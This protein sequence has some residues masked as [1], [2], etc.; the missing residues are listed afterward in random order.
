MANCFVGHINAHKPYLFTVSI[1]NLDGCKIQ[2]RYLERSINLS[3]TNQFRDCGFWQNVK[4]QM[5]ILVQ[6]EFEK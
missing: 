3:I 2:F 4:E 6:I 5:K 1:N